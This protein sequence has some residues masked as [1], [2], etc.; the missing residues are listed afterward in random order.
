MRRN[1]VLFALF[2]AAAAFWTIWLGYH[3][4]LSAD[5]IVVSAPQ[6]HY[7]TVVVVA[8]AQPAADGVARA[9]IIKVYKDSPEAVRAGPL[10]GEIAIRWTDKLPVLA[11][12]STF[13]LPLR[14]SEGRA[15]DLPLFE[16][17]LIPAPQGF[18]EGRIYPF[19]ESVR[20]QTERIMARK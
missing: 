6:L 14:S 7:A 5:P 10:P 17:A 15:G 18:F 16:A 1:K 2:A 19:S 13:L 12:P 4:R 11:A 9:K 8:E 20:M 3:A